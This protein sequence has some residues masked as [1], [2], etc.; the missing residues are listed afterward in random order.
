MKKIKFSFIFLHLVWKKPYT[1]DNFNESTLLNYLLGLL[2]CGHTVNQRAYLVCVAK[3][4][5][6]NYQFELFV[7]LF[8]DGKKFA[9]NEVLEIV[10][11]III[12][13]CLQEISS[14]K[15]GEASSW[16]VEAAEQ[17]T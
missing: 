6:Q 14:K 4:C 2:V 10:K 11:Y 15:Y 12:F 17:T 16:P 9:K 3:A 5:T 8:H 1:Q 7:C 13:I